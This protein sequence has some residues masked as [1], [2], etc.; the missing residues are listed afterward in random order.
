[1]VS[2]FDLWDQELA[3]GD[4]SDQPLMIFAIAPLVWVWVE[5]EE[6]HKVHR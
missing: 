1:M 2:H 5:V 3:S 4:L 6:L